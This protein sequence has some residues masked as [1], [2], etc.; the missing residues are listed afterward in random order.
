MYRIVFRIARHLTR[1]SA[2]LF[3]LAAGLTTARAGAQQTME[4]SAP[5][6]RQPVQVYGLPSAEQL[7]EIT[8]PELRMELLR[9]AGQD[10]T[11]RAAE[12]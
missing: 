2:V 4:R 8:H 10:Q 1:L 6:Q 5:E 11:A 7:S 3:L 12:S 9:M